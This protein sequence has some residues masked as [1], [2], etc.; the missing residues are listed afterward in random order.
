MGKLFTEFLG[1]FFLVLTM[2]LCVNQPLPLAAFA[3]GGILTALI[4]MGSHV[5]GA[6]YNPA[7]TV[8]IVLRGAM[9]AKDAL[10]YMA[11]Q[12]LGSVAAA[13][14]VLAINGSSF[15]PAPGE[16]VP[17]LASV[18]VELLFTFV[19]CL[20]I[21][22]TATVEEVAGNSYYGLAIGLVVSVAMLVIGPISGAALNPAFA[23][24][25]LLVD[26]WMGTAGYQ[27]LWI[28]IVGPFGGGA[29]AAV[30]FSALRED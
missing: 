14:M 19:M 4:Y 24:G 12:I 22:R 5:S 27:Q 29:L 7:A 16:N 10:P 18:L 3:V 8:A 28:Y 26:G 9:D 21:L 6:H 13:L 2:G 30:A 1:T 17:V 25:T 15:S 11:A 20:V 23:L